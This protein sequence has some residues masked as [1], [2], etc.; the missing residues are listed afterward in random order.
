MR[1][2]R[3]QSANSTR[4]SR[5]SS[6]NCLNASR[7]CEV[8]SFSMVLGPS[9]QRSKCVRSYQKSFVQDD[10]FRCFEVPM[11][12]VLRIAISSACV[13]FG[14]DILWH[15][16]RGFFDRRRKKR[17]LKTKWFRTPDDLLYN[18]GSGIKKKKKS[19]VKYY[20]AHITIRIYI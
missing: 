9:L 4:R 20:N 3:S 19:L 6:I 5:F 17:R 11:F 15:I 12:V 16:K 10:V 18:T 14:N 1:N 13:N 7:G 8:F 2:F